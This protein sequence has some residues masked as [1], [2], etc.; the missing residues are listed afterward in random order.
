MEDVQTLTLRLP[1]A[2]VALWQDAADTL[3][4]DRS[5]LF[6]AVLTVG[7]KDEAL[8]LAADRINARKSD[9]G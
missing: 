2:V 1:S 7:S 8:T 6:R 3:T 9:G 4:I 5:A